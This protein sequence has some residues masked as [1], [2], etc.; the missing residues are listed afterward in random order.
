MFDTLLKLDL[1]QQLLV[2]K[3]KTERSS[4]AHSN[5]YPPQGNNPPLYAHM[6]EYARYM[7]ST[8]SRNVCPGSHHDNMYVKSASC[9]ANTRSKDRRRR[10]SNLKVHFGGVMHSRHIRGRNPNSEHRIE[11]AL[12]PA[13]G[14]GGSRLRSANTESANPRAQRLRNSIARGIRSLEAIALRKVKRKFIR[15]ESRRWIRRNLQ[16]L[17]FPTKVGQD[18]NPHVSN[19][20]V[21]PRS[22]NENTKRRKARQIAKNIWTIKQCLNKTDIDT[23]ST[24]QHI[25]ISHQSTEIKYVPKSSGGGI[26]KFKN[27]DGDVPVCLLGKQKQS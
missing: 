11:G 7:H 2:G 23:T 17:T 14:A 8:R 18:D 21:K 5:T 15:K 27:V 1:D 10:R 3:D 19:K 25:T 4:Y 26:G 6:H 16:A 13:G 12:P 9:G 24:R 22:A 20:H